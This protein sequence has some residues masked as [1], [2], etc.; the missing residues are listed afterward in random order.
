MSKRKRRR[1]L[2][3]EE[4]IELYKKLNI[5]PVKEPPVLNARIIEHSDE[6]VEKMERRE[7]ERK[8]WNKMI[9]G[10]GLCGKKG[11]DN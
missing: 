11:H 6:E 4:L 5:P 2:T 7:K 10:D 1:G 9:R 3:R 8:F